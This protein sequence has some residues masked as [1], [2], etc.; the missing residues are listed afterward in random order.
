MIR[1]GLN[2]IAFKVLGD[3]C[4]GFLQGHVDDA[5]L[6]RSRAHPLDQTPALV[7]TAHRFDQQIEVGPVEAGGY[8]I[9]FCDIEFGLHVGNHIRRCRSGQQQGLR[10]VELALV[11]RQLEVVGT[12][13]VPPLGNTVRL[14]HDQ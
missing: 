10:D 13:I 3:V 6:A 4:G 11:V 2:A 1:L 7:L 5:R 8:H 9:F 12:E 14:V